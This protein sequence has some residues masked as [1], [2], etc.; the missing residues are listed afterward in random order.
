MTKD[1]VF[2]SKELILRRRQWFTLIIALDCG[3]K[4]IDHVAYAKSETSILLFVIT[5]LV[6]TT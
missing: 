2:H 5:D 3:I 1:T 4:S 6:L